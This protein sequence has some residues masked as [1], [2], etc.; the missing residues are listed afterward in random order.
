MASAQQD[1]CMGRGDAP[2]PSYCSAQYNRTSPTPMQQ[3][4]PV[5]RTPVYRDAPR[6]Q[7]PVY[8]A[9]RYVPAPQVSVTVDPY[10]ND[11][12]PAYTYDYSQW[13]GWDGQHVDVY[14]DNVL[15]MQ[16]VYRNDVGRLRFNRS[17]R[18]LI[19]VVPVGFSYEYPVYSRYYDAP[20]SNFSLSFSFG[21]NF[22]IVLR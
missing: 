8:R 11:Y 13:N 14:I 12:T 1:P 18:H 17:G 20:Q 9:P 3:A 5:Y 4:A 10:Y 19:R 2:L 15:V 7:P 21:G 16:N 22:N 6:Y